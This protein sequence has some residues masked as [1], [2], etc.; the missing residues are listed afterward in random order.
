MGE[1]LRVRVRGAGL[2]DWDWVSEGKEELTV[3]IYSP[4][5]GFLL[6]MVA[7]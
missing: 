7:T 1:V 4:F 2:R 3:S 6:A 5:A